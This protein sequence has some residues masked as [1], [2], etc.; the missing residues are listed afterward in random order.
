M[1]MSRRRACRIVMAG[2]LASVAS[3]RIRLVVLRVCGP[4]SCTRMSDMSAVICMTTS[5]WR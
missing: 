4:S 1:G 5:S 3:P 2:D